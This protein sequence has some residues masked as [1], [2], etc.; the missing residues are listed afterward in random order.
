VAV[1]EVGTTFGQFAGRH[2][3]WPDIA[4]TFSAQSNPR[5]ICTVSQL[6]RSRESLIAELHE[7]ERLDTDYYRQQDKSR[8]DLHAYTTRQER[9]RQILQELAEQ[10]HNRRRSSRLFL[11]I[12]VTL[13]CLGHGMIKGRIS[14][15]SASGFAAVLPLE[16]PYGQSVTAEIHLPFGT[17]TVEAVVRNRR[18]FRHGFEVLGTNLSEELDWLK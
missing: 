9:R 8:V 5:R 6:G 10:A 1:D 12:D 2:L 14:E 18:A 4:D 15:I 3:H 11:S 16:L 13:F 17:K 7:I